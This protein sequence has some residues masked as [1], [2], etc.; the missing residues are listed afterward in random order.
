MASGYHH[1]VALESLLENY[2]FFSQPFI[3]LKKS[4]VKIILNFLYLTDSLMK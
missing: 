4:E 1:S 2:K 3:F